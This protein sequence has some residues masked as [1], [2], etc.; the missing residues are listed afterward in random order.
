VIRSRRR[1]WAGHMVCMGERRGLY[2]VLVGKLQGKRP[3]RRTSC[4][5][6]MILDWILKK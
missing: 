3:L 4:I 5:R 2:R 6:R 1:K